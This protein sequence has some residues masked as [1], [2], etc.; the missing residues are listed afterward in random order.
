MLKYL[1]A[2]YHVH[3][4]NNKAHQAVWTQK[5]NQRR[6]EKAKQNAIKIE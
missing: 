1:T 4:K 3:D 6:Y 2:P 5:L